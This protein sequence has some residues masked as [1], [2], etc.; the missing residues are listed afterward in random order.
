M[1]RMQVLIDEAEYKRIQRV[2]RRNGMTLAEWVRQALRSAFR[3]EPLGGRD[4]KLATVRA[5]ASHEFPTADIDQMLDE[6]ARGYQ[7]AEPR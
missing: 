1:K 4:K 3:E 5:A 6:I 2:A 7:V